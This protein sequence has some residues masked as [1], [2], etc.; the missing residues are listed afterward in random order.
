MPTVIVGKNSKCGRT[1]TEKTHSFVNLRLQTFLG[2]WTNYKFNR[3]GVGERVIGGLDKI[4]TPLA[5]GKFACMCSG[6][7]KTYC[8]WFLDLL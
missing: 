8:A 4:P 6:D 1:Q 2:V 7:L 3:D 5:A